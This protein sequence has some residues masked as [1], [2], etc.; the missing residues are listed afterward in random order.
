MKITI[1]PQG[2]L[3]IYE[4]IVNQLKNAVVTGELKAGEALPSIRAL[5]A[6]LGAVSYTH[7]DVYKRQE[8]GDRAVLRAIHFFAEDERVVK[9]VN[10]LRAGDWNR[11][12]KLVKESG[13]S[14]YKYLQNV[15]VSHDTVSAVSYTHLDV[16]KRQGKDGV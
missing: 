8:S 13:D 16:Y 14:S 5:A 3:A 7:L 11:F 4:Q 2:T 10:A 6:D 1:L 9:E 15:Y 12:L